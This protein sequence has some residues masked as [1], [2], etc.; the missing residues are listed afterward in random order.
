MSGETHEESPEET[1]EVALEESPE[2]TPEVALDEPPG[3]VALDEPLDETTIGPHTEKVNIGQPRKGALCGAKTSAGT[4]CRRS[5]MKGGLRC[6]LH[7]GGSPLA[8][9]AAERR[10][11]YGVSLALDRLIE[12]LSEHDHEGPCPACGCSPVA[13]D[14]VVLRAA[15]GVLDRSGF[16]PGLRLQHSTDNEDTLREVRVRI[17]EVSAEQLE[18]DQASDRAALAER[19]ARHNQELEEQAELDATSEGEHSAADGRN[20]ISLDLETY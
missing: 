18:K 15:L 8:R 19:N 10:L 1:P 14:P 7:G 3:E 12:T 9:Q 2:Q 17:V 13:R 4:P 6:V 16:G 11:L 20:A 5:P